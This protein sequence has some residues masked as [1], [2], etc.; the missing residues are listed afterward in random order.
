V[1]LRVMLNAEIICQILRVRRGHRFRQCT[2]QFAKKLL[3][4]NPF[5]AIA[6]PVCIHPVQLVLRYERCP[7]AKGR[8]HSQYVLDLNASLLDGICELG[9][10]RS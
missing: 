2:P 6:L 5:Y 9:I 3:P 7:L 1:L 4:G 10:S 8:Q